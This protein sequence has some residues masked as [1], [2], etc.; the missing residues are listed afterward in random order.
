MRGLDVCPAGSMCLAIAF[1]N[2]AAELT[3]VGPGCT[4]DADA[5]NRAAF[6]SK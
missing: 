1:I 5:C 2:P 4:K 3:V 6:T